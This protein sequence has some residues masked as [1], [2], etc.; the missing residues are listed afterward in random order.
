[1]GGPNVLN[2]LRIEIRTVE[3]KSISLAGFLTCG[4]YLQTV[5][6]R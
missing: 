6:A 2:H 1:M 3:L 5:G 4:L